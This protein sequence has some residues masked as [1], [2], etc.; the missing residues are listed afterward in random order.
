MAD[1]FSITTPI[2]IIIFFGYSTTRL[3]IINKSDIRILGAFVIK[4]ALPA[5]I[6]RSLSQR[7]FSEIVNADF[8]SV[9][10]IASLSVFFL[11]FVVARMLGK[12]STAS[13]MQALGSSVSNSGFIG[14]PVAVL[15]LGPPAVIALALAM[16]VENILMI[17][18]A[19]VMAESGRNHGQNLSGIFCSVIHRLVTNPLII[20]ISIGTGISLSGLK[21]PVPLFRAI[22]MLAM[23]SGAVALFVVGGTL[24]GLRVRGMVADVGRIV[25]GKLFLHP[26]AVFITLLFV[27]QIDPNLKKAMLIFS[28]VSMFTV[29]PLMGQPYGHEDICAAALMVATTMS[30]LTISTLLLIL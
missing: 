27:P 9:Y 20:A 10:A 22:D 21:L 26:A 24:V 8:L 7:T 13:A 16:M 18:L 4:F 11:A 1:V 15:V 3:Y 19:L 29:Y 30:F 12:S 5:L 14:Y 23:A 28:S 25:V 2:F 6:L 17:P